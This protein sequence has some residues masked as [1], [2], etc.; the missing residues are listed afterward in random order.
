MDPAHKEQPDLGGHF[1][2]WPA[3]T[4]QR[5]VSTCRRSAPRSG[6]A[7]RPDAGH[8]N[9]Q[10]GRFGS[11]VDRDV[12][13]TCNIRHAH[14][15]CTAFTMLTIKLPAVV[16]SCRPLSFFSSSYTPL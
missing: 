13:T 12:H 9:Q 8:G 10:C 3:E 11:D 2:A 4:V 7:W 1:H 15:L 14:G 6:G 16:G 5:A